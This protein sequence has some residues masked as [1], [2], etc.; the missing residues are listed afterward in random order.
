[1]P[2]EQIRLIGGVNYDDPNSIFPQGYLKEARNVVWRGNPGNMRVESAPGTRNIANNA[3]PDGV[4]R[5]VGRIYDDIKLRVI[6]MNYNGNGNHAIYIY[7]TMSGSV[8]TLLSVGVATDGDILG[9]TLNRA[10]TSVNILYGDETQGDTLYYIDTIGRPTVINIDKFLNFP[11]I[12][13]KRQYI[14]VGTIQ[15]LV[16]LS[17]SY[18]NDTTV[19]VNNVKKALYQFRY[20][21][22]FTDNTKSSYSTASKTPLPYEPFSSAVDKDYTFNARI[23]MFIPTGPENVKKIELI[24]RQ[25]KD[26]VISDWFL[27]KTF[28]KAEMSL[29]DDDWY[30]YKFYNDGLYPFVDIKESALL[31]DYAPR[32]ASAMELLNGNTLIIGGIEEGYD[33]VNINATAQTG[34]TTLI[35]DIPGV[36]FFVEPTSS[37]SNTIKIHLTGVGT[38]YVNGNP[39]TLLNSYASFFV[40][41][42]DAS[43]VNRSFFYIATGDVNNVSTILSGLS[44]AAV[45]AGFTLVSQ[46]TNLLT[47]S[48]AGVGGALV[49]SAFTQLDTINTSLN[50]VDGVLY[51]LNS[52]AAYSWGLV[53]YDGNGVTNGV[54]HPISGMDITTADVF[55]SSSQLFPST[56]IT[57][58][59]R[60]PLWAASY[61]LVRTKDLTYATFLYWASLECLIDV[62]IVTATTYGY[63]NITNIVDY[64]QVLEGSKS[65]ITYDFTPGDRIRFIRRYTVNNTPNQ[66]SPN[67]ETDILSL[68]VNPIIGGIQRSGN[69]LRIKYDS[70]LNFNGDA[71]H[72]KYFFLI[73]NLAKHSSDEDQVYYEVGEQYGI[74]NPGA[75]NA[76]H[77]GKNQ[78]QTSNLSQPAISN[79]YGV[80]DRFYRTR[81]I[82]V[83]G[84]YHFIGGNYAS[85]NQ[86]VTP[87]IST[88]PLTVTTPRYSIKQELLNVNANITTS[89]NNGDFIFQNT[90]GVNTTIRLKGS[91][92]FTTDTKNKTKIYA[93]ICDPTVPF[94]N[95]IVL[96]MC[97]YVSSILPG[98]QVIVNFDYTFVVPTNGKVYLVIENTKIDSDSYMSVGIISMTMTIVDNI[99]TQVIDT[100]FSDTLAITLSDDG[101]ALIKDENE[102]DEFYPTKAR[103]SLQYQVE[104]NINQTNRFYPLNYDEYDRSRGAIKRFKARDKNLRVFQ[105]RGVG[106][107]G[108]YSQFISNS[109]GQTELILSKDIITQNN[110]QY[111][112]GEYGMGNQD[113]SLASSAGADYFCDPIRGYQV[114]LSQDGFTP[115][116]ELYKAQYFL[117]PILKQYLTNHLTD[118]GGIARILGVYDF[119]EEE[120]ISVFQPGSGITLPTGAFR[121]N[122][123]R[124]MYAGWYDY[125]PEQI[126][127]A[128]ETIMYW[129]NGGLFIQDARQNGKYCTYSETLHPMVIRTAFN[130]G[131]DMKKEFLSLSYHSNTG[132]IWNA[133][134]IGDVNTALGQRSN[135][136]DSDFEFR[137][138]MYHGAFWRDA[139]SVGGLINGDF[140]KGLWLDLTLQHN[141]AN[142]NFINEIY[143]NW[144]QSPKNY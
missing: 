79:I 86:Y 28:N 90:S 33:Q 37:L 141:S 16:P 124:N 5:C 25:S 68:D 22:T 127:C 144:L 77:F 13:T 27:I 41:A 82:P 43:Q 50:D 116:S 105:E 78:S 121:F 130:V 40:Q 120:F 106:V 83:G 117:P 84:I 128:E 100:Y 58:N 55:T 24:G 8:Q 71:D 118:V 18:E 30:Y 19:T 119:F 136:V 131:P 54:M 69:Y 45:T 35:G 7:N 3:L 143:L 29:S 101:R 44:A 109:Q 10:I 133:P 140:L 111:Y 63:I 80:G 9:F 6:W 52:R 85:A 135:M 134:G 56:T 115:I 107:V 94:P 96:S 46:T 60:P 64:N 31:F 48:A 122:E 113:A 137:E 97:E 15:P 103:Y 93:K 81:S 112:L 87:A 34:T 104:T 139:D 62:N 36:N 65:V 42:K 88:T 70:N 95:P 17:C 20:R 110:I 89:I 47:L 72:Q 75:V 57:I 32:N 114:R 51:S 39:I 61:Q 142:F 12:L 59:S 26:G 138:G 76:Y 2:A 126:V 73:Y 132:L 21:Y 92:P 14:D 1:M 74:G 53:Y 102:R 123:P 98:E 67:I 38:N 49:T 66:I 23:G 99:V 91:Y 125:A 129:L 4:N 108:V 11:Y